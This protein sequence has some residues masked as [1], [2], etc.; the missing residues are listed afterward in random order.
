MELLR[1]LHQRQLGTFTGDARSVVNERVAHHLPGLLQEKEY[2]VGSINKVFASSWV[3]DRQIVTGTKCNKLMILDL[4]TR[5]MVQIPSL[6]SSHDSLPADCPCGIHSI[7]IN[8]SRTLLAT[9]AENTNDVAVYRL[10]T[11]DPVCLGEGGHKDWIFD[12]KWLDDE[13]FVTG[14]RDSC[15]ALWCVKDSDY[16]DFVQVERLNM[17]GYAINQPVF[18]KN[19]HNAEKIRALA[20]NDQ[21]YHLAAL[22]L[23]AQLHI[24][25]TQTWK[26]IESRKLPHVRENVCMALSKDRSLYAV[27]SQSHVSYMDSRS[28]KTISSVQSQLRGCGIRSVSFNE[29]VV[30]IGTGAGA[31]LFYDLNAG[32]YLE[33]SCGHACMLNAGK[34]W[35][36][37][38]E[39]YMDIFMDQ[40]YP[41]A[42]Y[43]HCYDDSG[44]KLFAAGGPL[45]AGLHGNYCG[46][47][48]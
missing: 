32:K 2:N 11:F 8:P 25:D 9:G 23:D 3:S 43:T 47:W 7:A 1:F 4:I 22:S 41:N 30:T 31:I 26:Q 44:T 17:P 19:C 46:L 21:Q 24:W 20:Y 6:K 29:N 40:D 38:D 34:G 15:I 16:D 33:C 10:P 28:R 12:I 42:I 37:R 35:L 36:L 13:F 5:Q 48:L 27:G 45:P 14:A 18:V 39:T